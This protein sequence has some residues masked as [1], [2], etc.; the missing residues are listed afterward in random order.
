MRRP[1]V[2]RHAKRMPTKR[3][4]SPITPCSG[5]CKSSSGEAMPTRIN[6]PVALRILPGAFGGADAPR[7]EVHRLADDETDGQGHPTDH[8][9][10]EQ[11][12]RD[13]DR[14]SS[15]RPGNPKGEGA[16][17]GRVGVGRRQRLN[18]A[19]AFGTGRSAVDLEIITVDRSS[20]GRAGPRRAANAL[21]SKSVHQPESAQLGGF[22][23]AVSTTSLASARSSMAV[24]TDLNKVM[25]SS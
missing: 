14:K 21:I 15:D 22:R 6:A 18:L 7:S 4:T 9:P 1:V 20:A 16:D 2:N 19:R 12:E 3:M 24:P 25:S 8:Q 13:I 17:E 10:R 5:L 23:V 11:G